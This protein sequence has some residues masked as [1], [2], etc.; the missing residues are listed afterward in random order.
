MFLGGVTGKFAKDKRANVTMIFA[1]AMIPII[2]VAGFA[3]DLQLAFS[4]KNKV[5]AAVDSAV[6]AGARLMQT[7]NNQ[8]QVRQHARAYFD[9]IMADKKGGMWCDDLN[10]KFVGEEELEGDVDC[11]QPTTLTRIFGKQ[12][13]QFQTASTATYGVG[14]LDVAFV[15][16]ISGSMNWGTK[17]SDLKSAAKD[18]ADILLPE[19]GASGDGDVRIAMVAYNNMVNAGPYFEEVTG[20]KP[21]RTYTEDVT[22]TEDEWYEEEYTDREH[23]CERQC[24]RQNKHGKCTRTRNVCE[25]QD[26]TKTRWAVREV[27]KTRTE[28]KTITSTCVYERGG[29]HKFSEREPKQLKPGD[30]VDRLPSGAYNASPNAANDDAYLAAGYATWDDYRERWNVYGDNDCRSATPFQ[31]NDNSEQIENYIEALSANGGTAGHQGIEWGWYLISPEFSDIF[32]GKAAPLPYNE[33]DGAKAM[34]IMTDGE[35][36][37]QLFGSQGNSVAQAKA[38]CDEIKAKDIIIYTVAF[39]A[40]QQGKDVLAYCAS[41]VEFA[42]TAQN[43][44]ELTESYK[45]IATSISDLRIKG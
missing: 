37:S 16:D 25:W 1:L 20:L 7:T 45:A 3:I 10:L 42:F 44:G 43:A 28:E 4:K 9:A 39:D 14:K 8:N 41:G 36:N 17:L 34:I 26:V 6:L 35:F 21:R 27:E 29:T 40:P 33:P 23:V 22:Y 38:L 2:S 12:K 5:Q 13:L 30:L 18:A 32:T 11:Y 15:F 19:P 24:T 31:L